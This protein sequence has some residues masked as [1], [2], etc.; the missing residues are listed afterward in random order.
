M[1]AKCLIKIFKIAIQRIKRNLMLKKQKLK[2][3]MILL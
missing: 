2:L 1:N 3:R